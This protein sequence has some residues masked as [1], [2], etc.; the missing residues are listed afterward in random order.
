VEP[1]THDHIKQVVA[2]NA[3]R[4]QHPLG[5]HQKGPKKYSCSETNK[6]ISKKRKGVPTQCCQTAQRE[7][8]GNPGRKVQTYW[9]DVGGE[10]K[11]RKQVT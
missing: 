5:L 10:T 11:V 6:S 2:T 9:G 1:G 4:R 3:D 7:G 8:G